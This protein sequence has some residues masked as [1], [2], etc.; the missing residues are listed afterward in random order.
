MLPMCNANER[1]TTMKQN[2]VLLFIIGIA[3]FGCSNSDD[4]NNTTSHFNDKK[5][6]ISQHSVNVTTFNQ[7]LY[8]NEFYFEIENRN[9]K[10]FA[11]GHVKFKLKNDPNIYQT[12]TAFI[13]TED[14][15]YPAFETITSVQKMSKSD[16]ENYSLVIDAHYP[17]YDGKFNNSA[18]FIREFYIYNPKN[19]YPEQEKLTSIEFYIDNKTILYTAQAYVEFKIKN[20]D[21][22]YRTKTDEVFPHETNRL[23]ISIDYPD[24]SK[25]DIEYKKVIV[26]SYKRNTLY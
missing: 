1:N 26:E 18:V 15:L 11:I 13:S 10:H 24:L 22:I 5:T 17:S 4:D 7:G 25:H 16:I 12:G 19:S 6:Y 23:L 14:E 2:L 20:K 21:R 9:K 3:S 8:F